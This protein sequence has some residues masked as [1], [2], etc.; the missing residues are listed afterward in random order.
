MTSVYVLGTLSLLVV[1]VIVAKAQIEQRDI[2]RGL[3]IE[4]PARWRPVMRWLGR[5]GL[6]RGVLTRCGRGWSPPGFPVA[7]WRRRPG[8]VSSRSR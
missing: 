7:P 6:S 3:G 5:R 2:N 4:V 8:R 1:S